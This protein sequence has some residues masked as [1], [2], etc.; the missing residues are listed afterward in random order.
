MSDLS[1]SIA[2][3]TLQFIW[4]NEAGIETYPVYK[5]VMHR[6]ALLSLVNDFSPTTDNQDMATA[7]R[8]PWEEWGPS[9][10]SWFH[11]DVDIDLTSFARAIWGQRF[12]AMYSQKSTSEEDVDS[13]TSTVGGHVGSLAY[14]GEHMSNEVVSDEHS[15][16]EDALL[17]VYNFNPATVSSN[18]Y[19]VTSA[20]TFKAQERTPF[21]E[22]IRCLLPHTTHSLQVPNE[23]DTAVLYEE[24][25]ALLGRSGEQYSP[26]SAIGDIECLRMGY[27]SN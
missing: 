15:A 19:A 27:D 7:A 5:F 14:D 17:R 18:E 4:V 9:R 10:T 1:K 24:G 11:S 13:T 23:F 22:D 8:V 16:G 21:A 6:Q 26:V 25:I 2:A 12:V 20:K 3:F